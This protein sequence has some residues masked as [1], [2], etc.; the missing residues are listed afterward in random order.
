MISALL[1]RSYAGLRGREL[2]ADL[3]PEV[4]LSLA[5]VKAR[6]LARGRLASV[7]YGDSGGMHLRGP[8]TV[9]R[10]PSGLR[11]GNGVIFAADVEVWAF[12]LNG[13]RLGDR[14]TVGRGASLL[15]SGVVRE[16]GVGIDIGPDTA[17]GMHNVIWG[18]GGVS[19]GRD[20]LLGPQVIMVSENHTYADPS[21]PLREQPGAR[22]AISIGDDCW[23]G[24]GA[25]V[26]AGVTIGE[27]C[28]IG[29][30]AVV[31]TSIPAGSIAGGV[32][33]R[34]VGHR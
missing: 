31:T 6:D 7:R 17:I 28:V 12:S 16:P 24:A 25:K 9:V 5:A 29:A 18:Q 11:I 22:A 8:R 33:A 13:I 30:G 26:L 34:V 23:L 27:R 14:V 10:H 32:P 20:C 19:I 2:P 4:L 15:A 21:R 1:R 3:P